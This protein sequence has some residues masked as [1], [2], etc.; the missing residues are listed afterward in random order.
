MTEARCVSRGVAAPRTAPLDHQRHGREIRADP[1]NSSSARASPPRP[2]SRQTPRSSALPRPPLSSGPRAAAA[3]ACSWTSFL[4][5]SPA[6]A[7]PSSP[8]SSCGLL[9]RELPSRSAGR[10]AVGGDGDTGGGDP[11]PAD[12]GRSS[13]SWRSC[14]FDRYRAPALTPLTPPEPA[15]RAAQP[16]HSSAGLSPRKKQYPQPDSNRRSPA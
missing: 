12:R 4:I 15:R 16:M 2:R 11:E 14:P 10:T 13:A 7:L 8:R 5:T 6:R 3:K 1:P 9:G